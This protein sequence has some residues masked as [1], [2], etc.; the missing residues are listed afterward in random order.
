MSELLTAAADALS[1]PESLVQRSAAARATA[2]GTSVDDVLSAWSGGAP[3][4]GAAPAPSP[5][6][7]E[8]EAPVATEPATEAPAPPPEP[9]AQPEVVA[10]AAAVVVA[11][12][13]PEVVLEPVPLRRRVQTAIRVGA[14]T[15]AGLGLIGF[16]VASN[17]WAPTATVT[18][19]ETFT[20][21]I[22]ASS[23]GV[24]IGAA[25][26]SV[27]FGAVIASL[28]RAAASWANPGMQLSS[29]PS[30]TFWV[31]ALIGVVLGVV[32]GAV[33]TGLGT[34][35]EGVEGAVQLPVLPTVAVMAIG[36]ALL[37]ALTAALTQAIGVPVAVPEGADEEIATVRTRLGWAFGVPLTGLLLLLLLVLP[38]AWTLLESNHLTSGG[39]AIV[40]ILTAAG[41][42]GFASLAGTKPNIK[43]SFGEVM[44][45][46]IGIGTIVV[47]VLAVLFARSPEE[48]HEEPAAEPEAAVV[49]VIG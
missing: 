39:A 37:G 23:N 22:Q 49:L 28:S 8:E 17:W 19:E 38:F 26:I 46:V 25:L 42:L 12:P 35:V 1:V 7:T 30:S 44:V 18:G 6:A 45:A 34:P 47:F 21:V 10:P 16:V 27:V 13:E 11:E 40:G 41:I 9:A 4:A 20:P 36:G 24:I 32:A 15:G 5:P 3:A 43:L 29:K 2:N 31:G 48:E 14:W 33:L